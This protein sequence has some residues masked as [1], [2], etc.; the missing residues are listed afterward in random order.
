MSQDMHYG[1]ACALRLIL[2]PVLFI[3]Y[4][5]HVANTANSHGEMLNMYAD[6]CQLYVDFDSSP[7]QF[8]CSRDNFARPSLFPNYR[9]ETVCM[10]QFRF[11]RRFLLV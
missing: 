4:T 7:T 3:L 11:P 9:Y 6:D 8:N 2:G 5:K 10:T 1:T